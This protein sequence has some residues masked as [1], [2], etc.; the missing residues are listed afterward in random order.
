MELALLDV[1]MYHKSRNLSMYRQQTNG[2]KKPKS[3]RRHSDVYEDQVKDKDA[4]S[5]AN[6]IE[7]LTYRSEKKCKNRSPNIIQR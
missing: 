2:E 3:V 7:T 6:G 5:G 1:R 4:Y